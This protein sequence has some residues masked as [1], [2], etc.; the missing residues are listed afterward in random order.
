MFT[1]PVTC[2][3]LFYAANDVSLQMQSNYKT[4]ALVICIEHMQQEM[5]EHDTLLI[6]C[7]SNLFS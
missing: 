3:S 2:I 6:A 4:K 1:S 5:K 7:Q